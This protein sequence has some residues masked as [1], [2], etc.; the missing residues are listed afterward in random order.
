MAP[1]EG[2]RVRPGLAA[3]L[4][5]RQEPAL[6]QPLPE[7]QQE[8][9]GDVSG[10]WHRPHPNGKGTQRGWGGLK[11]PRTHG[12]KPLG[13]GPAPSCLSFPPAEVATSSC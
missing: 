4:V 10:T 9:D 2:G 5:G 8:R 3:G 13:A 1:W 7:K 11:G 6:S 12:C